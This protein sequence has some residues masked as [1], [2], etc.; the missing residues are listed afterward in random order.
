MCSLD[1]FGSVMKMDMACPRQ[2]QV[3]APAWIAKPRKVRRTP[4]VLGVSLRTKNAARGKML[5]CARC[6]CFKLR[7]FHQ[8]PSPAANIGFPTWNSLKLDS[9]SRWLDAWHSDSHKNVP[10]TKMLQWPC[11]WDCRISTKW[12][13]RTVGLL[14]HGPAAQRSPKGDGAKRGPKGPA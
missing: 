13:I 8:M 1:C 12:P 14:A 3:L 4:L 2:I 10:Y 6:L 11:I 7:N 5:K 9:T